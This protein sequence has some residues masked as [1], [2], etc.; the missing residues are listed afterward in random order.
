ML[1]PIL[2][3]LIYLKEAVG[4]D[5]E[6]VAGYDAE[7]VDFL[8]SDSVIEEAY[9]LE[10]PVLI[11]GL[12]RVA[13]WHDYDE[14]SFSLFELA[15]EY[16]SAVAYYYISNYYP[17]DPSHRK[18]L[19]L[20]ALSLDF[21]PAVEAVN[22]M[23][24]V[25]NETKGLGNSASGI[26]SDDTNHFD[27]ANQYESLKFL[28]LMRSQWLYKRLGCPLLLPIFYKKTWI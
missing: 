9:S 21:P 3:T 8:L 2:K 5:D 14:L 13:Y 15:T 7:F 11:A 27:S 12:G 4:V 22:N 19:L 20:A 26:L 16:E 6:T 10:D 1:L 28:P 23:S 24:N 18:E 17:D 25:G